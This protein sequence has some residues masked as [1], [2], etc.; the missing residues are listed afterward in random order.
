MRRK[1]GRNER[2][3]VGSRVPACV[4]PASNLQVKRVNQL[5]AM[6]GLFFNSRLAITSPLSH[7]HQ[8]RFRERGF[9]TLVLPTDRCLYRALITDE[10]I[11][12]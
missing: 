9:V 11:R 10:I 1:V 6:F 7:P 3:R 8:R 5:L 4:R 2:T 12:T